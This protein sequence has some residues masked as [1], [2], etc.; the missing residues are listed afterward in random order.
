MKKW[1]CTLLVSLL[2]CFPALADLPREPWPKDPP[3]DG[4]FGWISGRVP[5]LIIAVVLLIASVALW[6]A[7][8]AHKTK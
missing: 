7:V 4:I 3:D 8:R 2:T 1:L 5:V 6:M